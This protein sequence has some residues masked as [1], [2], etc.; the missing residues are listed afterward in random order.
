MLYCVLC[1]EWLLTLWMGTRMNERTW[2][3]RLH[4]L[5][6]TEPLKHRACSATP[7]TRQPSRI[8]FG[9]GEGRREDLGQRSLTNQFLNFHQVA[10]SIGDKETVFKY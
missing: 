7:N 6:S 5:V 8:L 3:L 9:V 10:Y 1:T 2:V 4:L